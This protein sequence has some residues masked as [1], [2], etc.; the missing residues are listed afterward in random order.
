M[1][2]FFCSLTFTFEQANAS[3]ITWNS[4]SK[5]KTVEKEISW[6]NNNLTNEELNEVITL[7]SALSQPEASQL[8]VSHFYLDGSAQH[9]SIK[10]YL[11]RLAM[12]PPSG[13]AGIIKVAYLAAKLHQSLIKLKQ[14]N[15]YY[16]AQF[17]RSNFE[18]PEYNGNDVNK[19]IR[20]S[21]DYQPAQVVLDILST[22]DISYKEIITKIS[23]RQFNELI[24][25][26]NQSFYPTP[27][28]KEKLA[29][30]LQ[31]ASSTKPIDKL[32]RYINPYG[33]LNFTDVKQN[34]ARYKQQI[35]IL[36]ANETD[37]SDYINT[38]VSP[39][40]PIKTQ[41]SRRV[42]FFLSMVLMAGRQMM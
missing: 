37:M 24:R 42:S 13:N 29:T 11:E 3:T 16:V 15:K 21:F 14:S 10:P 4:L 25:H 41:F 1:V 30:C 8:M 35:N 27:L 38:Q 9:K 32:Y 34:L 28:T 12:R 7:V 23:L 31:I 22:S 6:L 5:S 26:R 40:L 2:L 39:Y 33:L 18:L 19:K 20:L 17:S 36:K